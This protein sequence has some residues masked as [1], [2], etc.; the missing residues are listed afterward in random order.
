[1]TKEELA[2]K[3]FVA[4]WKVK[5]NY[6]SLGFETDEDYEDYWEGQPQFEKEAWVAAAIVAATIATLEDIEGVDY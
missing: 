4:A 1:M 6:A 3:M 5:N 2:K